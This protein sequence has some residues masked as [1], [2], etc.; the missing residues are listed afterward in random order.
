VL[1]FL[2]ENGESD[3]I[4]AMVLTERHVADFGAGAHGA[5]LG[6]DQNRE[7]RIHVLWIRRKEGVRAA[8]DVGELADV[9]RQSAAQLINARSEGFEVI[10]ILNASVFNDLL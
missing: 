2:I 4:S 6:F 3:V 8:G 9:A 5:T 7:Q 10:P 1:H